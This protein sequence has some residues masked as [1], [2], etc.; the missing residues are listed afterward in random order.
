MPVTDPRQKTAVNVIRVML[1]DDHEVVRRGCRHLLESTPDIQVVGEAANSE[2]AVEMYSVLTPDVLVLDISMPGTGGLETVRRVRSHDPHARILIFSMHHDDAM[3]LRTIK[4]GVTGY[5]TKSGGTGQMIDA[6]RRVAR[7]KQYIDSE[8]A[9]ELL[10]HAMTQ[11]TNEPL[12]ILSPREFQ[13]FQRLAEGQPTSEIAET[14]SI[15]P[16]TVAAHRSSIMR[17]LKLKTTSDLV[18]LAIRCHAIQP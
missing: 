8:R 13:L 7:G 12:D 10:T 1:A 6:I 18:R 14:L 3:I 16:K 9:S 2:T 11:H 5:L 4:A 15:S 17:K